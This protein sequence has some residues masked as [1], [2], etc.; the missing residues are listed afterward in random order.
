MLM[1]NI[2]FTDDKGTCGIFIYPM[3]DTRAQN[4]VDA[5][6]I[7]PAMKHYRIHKRAAVMSGCGMN[8]H[9]LWFIND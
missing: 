5:G 4:P 7:I 6:K 9:P 8:Y 2:V 3:H 1:G